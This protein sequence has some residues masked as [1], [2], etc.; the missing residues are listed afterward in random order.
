MPETVEYG[1]SSFV[2]R[3]R[4][5]FHPGRFWTFASDDAMWKRVTRSKGFLWL[6]SRHDLCGIWSSAGPTASLEAAGRWY[7]AV[8]RQEWDVDPETLASIEADW[9]VP[10]GDRRQELVLIGQS[11]DQ[12]QFRA[13]LDAALLTDDEL[14]LGPERWRR[15]RD[16][17]PAWIVG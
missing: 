2:Y 16:P 9:Q 14:A 3:A 4:K 8:P 1:I 10:H 13:G 11:I 7:A 6:A 12:A 17:F 15:Y 5:P